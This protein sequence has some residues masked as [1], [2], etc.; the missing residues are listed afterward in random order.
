MI[1]QKIFLLSG[2]V[3]FFIIDFS[4]YLFVGFLGPDCKFFGEGGHGPPLSLSSSIP[5]LIKIKIHVKNLVI[6]LVAA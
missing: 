1:C 4:C 2:Y 3:H 6:A 5:G